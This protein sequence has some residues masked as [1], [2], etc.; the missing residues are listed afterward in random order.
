MNVVLNNLKSGNIYL[1]DVPEYHFNDKFKPHFP[2]L[3]L[4]FFRIN[5]NHEIEEYNINKEI[6]IKWHKMQGTYYPYGEFFKICGSELYPDFIIAGQ[7]LAD[8]FDIDRVIDEIRDDL[9]FHIVQQKKKNNIK[10][11]KSEIKNFENLYKRM[12]YGEYGISFAASRAIGIWLWDYVNIYYPG[13]KHVEAIKALRLQG[14][15][16]E[17]SESD[18]RTLYRLLERT[19]E[20]IEKKMVLPIK[21]KRGRKKQG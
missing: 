19:T 1:P 14:L 21:A 18:D 3:V 4:S 6:W 17:H 11:T 16:V 13:S 5:P 2:E 7:S 20:C 15:D 10:L 8:E 9:I 12:A